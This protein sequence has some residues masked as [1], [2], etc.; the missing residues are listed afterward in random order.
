MLL[1]YA[2]YGLAL[3]SEVAL[4]ELEAAPLLDAVNGV[5][6][7]RLGRGAL[8]LGDPASLAYTSLYRTPGGEPLL[9]IYR[10]GAGLLLHYPDIAAF[11][12]HADSVTV[13][14]AK[15][16]HPRRW[17]Q[18]L[19][20][21]ALS[22]L[23]ELRGVPCLHAAAVVMD[24]GAVGF[25][26]TSTGGKTVLASTFVEAGTTLLCDDILAVRQKE[27]A[28]WGEPGPP[29]LKVWPEA[30]RELLGDDW[31]H[32]EP[33]VPRSEKRRLAVGQHWGAFCSAPQPLQ[34]LYVPHRTDPSEGTAIEVAPLPP[35]AALIELVRHSFCARIADALGWQQRR[36]E[37][38]AALVEQVPIRRLR[39][40]S[41]F[42]HLP[43]VRETILN[44]VEENV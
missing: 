26:A 30:A 25:L 37:L 19:L 11:R 3:D 4:P 44:D 39:Y 9:R 20:G 13:F 34:T 16:C 24:G 21:P 2:V 15:G 28:F 27:D 32:L 22:V 31:Q 14:P 42:S 35:G 17:R 1:R 7:V 12:V 8:P 29:Q 40:P 38:L 43:A 18:F 10:E 41:G 5:V 36:L 33:V 23:L 6:R